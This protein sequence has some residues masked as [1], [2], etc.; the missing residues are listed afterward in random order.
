MIITFD[1][2]AGSGKSTIAKLVAE[3]LGYIHFN[4]GSIFRAITAYL[5]ENNKNA[6][7]PNGKRAHSFPQFT[8]C[9]KRKIPR[10]RAGFADPFG[11]PLLSLFTVRNFFRL[12]SI[13]I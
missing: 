3:H 8:Q 6:L 13:V 4:S 2:P 10:V 9:E 11:H 5:L 7:S 12:K 1:G